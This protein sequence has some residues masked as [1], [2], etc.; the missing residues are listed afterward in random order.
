MIRVAP[1]LKLNDGVGG[2]RSRLGLRALLECG[3]RACDTRPDSVLGVPEYGA[4]A[5]PGQRLRALPMKR[6]AGNRGRVAI[7]SRERGGAAFAACF[8]DLVTQG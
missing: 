8:S 7:A 3:L 2:F 6:R 4:L 1:L 5:C